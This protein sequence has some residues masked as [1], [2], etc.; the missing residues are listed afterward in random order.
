MPP[1][2]IAS[3]HYKPAD[4]DRR[5]KE[6]RAHNATLETESHF[7]NYFKN[8]IGSKNVMILAGPDTQNEAETL[9]KM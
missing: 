7:V 6:F 9:A 3:E 5:L 8:I 4:M 1:E 2:R